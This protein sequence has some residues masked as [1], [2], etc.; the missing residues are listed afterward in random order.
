MTRG[1]KEEAEITGGFAI[2]YVRSRRKKVD[3]TPNRVEKNGHGRRARQSEDDQAHG[4]RILNTFGKNWQKRKG[5]V[6]QI[7]KTILPRFSEV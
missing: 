5:V 6:E 2:G 3:I 7:W 1:E 4:P